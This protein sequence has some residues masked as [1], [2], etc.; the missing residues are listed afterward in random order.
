M[1]NHRLGCSEITELPLGAT[2]GILFSGL[3]SFRPRG[4]RNFQ[5]LGSIGPVVLALQKL[6]GNS[7]LIKLE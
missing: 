4:N 3:G 1:G 5:I 6:I 2:L 7:F